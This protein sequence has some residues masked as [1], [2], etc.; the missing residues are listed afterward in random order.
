MQSLRQR[1]SD[2]AEAAAFARARAG[3]HDSGSAP[4]ANTHAVTRRSDKDLV[5]AARKATR[6]AAVAL[7]DAVAGG[8]GPWRAVCRAVG[9]SLQVHS[10][11]YY[12]S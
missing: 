7:A 2:T 11:P 6:E 9:R 12:G 4:S 3:L 1:A 10:L 5:K 8:I